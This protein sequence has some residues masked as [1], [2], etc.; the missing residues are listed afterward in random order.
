MEKE[1]IP[2]RDF[3]EL[4]SPNKAFPDGANYHI[5]VAGVERASIMEAMIDEAKKRKIVV[6]RAIAAVG[7]GRFVIFKSLLLCNRSMLLYSKISE[8][9][10]SG[11]CLNSYY[12][13]D[14]PSSLQTANV[15]TEYL[16]P[17]P[18]ASRFHKRSRTGGTA[19]QVLV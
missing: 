9:K 8:Q 12:T 11:Q 16:L 14:G 10:S 15:S 2:G 5:E 19:L 1:G 6:H 3:Y 18:A 13:Q 7:G 4:P 17:F